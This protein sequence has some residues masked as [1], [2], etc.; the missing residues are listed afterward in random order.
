MK[1]LVITLGSV[2]MAGCLIGPFVLFAGWVYD[3]D[4]QRRLRQQR[5]HLDRGSP[6][7]ETGV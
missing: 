1:E 4:S 7:K 5:R 6:N 2:I 3:C